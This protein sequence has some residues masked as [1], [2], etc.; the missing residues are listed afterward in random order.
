LL[1]RCRWEGRGEEDGYVEF[2]T[3]GGFA[4]GFDDGERK[5]W[6]RWWFDGEEQVGDG[7]VRRGYDGAGDTT[8]K[9]EGEATVVKKE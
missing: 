1:S 4:V 7:R 9:R 5:R 8:A 2:T 6:R 3:G